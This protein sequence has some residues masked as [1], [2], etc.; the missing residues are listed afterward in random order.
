[1]KRFVLAARATALLCVLSWN[2]GA[3][4]ATDESL[5]IPSP[6]PAPVVALPS[7]VD[8]Q[9]ANGLAATMIPYGTVPKT[10]IV[11]T[12]GTGSI[13]DG[14]RPGLASLA[15]DL[16]K[17][18]V[19]GNNAA[20]L[21][22]RAADMG[23]AININA[24]IDV[25]SISLDVLSEYTADAIH[26]IGELLRTPTLPES[27]L[28]RLKTDMKRAIAIGHSQQ[29][30]IASEAFAKR[31]F[32]NSPRGRRTE[33]ADVEAIMFRDITRFLDNQLSAR[34]T[35]IYLAGRFDRLAVERA[36][37]ASFDNWKTGEPALIDR[38]QA[39][40]IGN[41]ELID[42]PG[43]K[44][45]TLLIGMP[46]RSITSPGYSDL[47]LANAILGGSGLMSRLDQN[48]REDKGWTY[49]VQSQIE[50][51]SDSSLWMLFADINTPDTA[52]AIREIY[53]ELGRLSAEI[54]DSGELRRTQ[55]YRA[56]HFL[57]GASS[58]AGL[59]G[60]LEFVDRHELGPDWLS[61]YLQRLQAV[62]TDGVR[63]AAAEFDPSRMTIVVAGDLS[64]IKSELEGIEALKGAV[65]H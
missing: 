14:D 64:R 11:V 37:H 60:Q 62:T 50:P 31:L 22:Q 19:S 13:A 20:A 38:S 4:G 57:M 6:G 5:V 33:E 54:P 46:L 23:G 28:G 25:F 12:V 45:S 65:L 49:G 35:R 3:F 47:S 56:G 61:G 63:L 36:I 53:A 51:L 10:T 15:A 17:Q 34:R 58:R 2:Q 32:G 39:T 48:L 9:L 41:V 40:A 7:R 52:A 26:L 8:F 55:N 21:F 44:Q 59:I 1:M 29:Q 30:S 43:A 27:E 18:G 16:M 42:R 24:G